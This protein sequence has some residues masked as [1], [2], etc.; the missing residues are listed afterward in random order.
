MAG[1]V[2]DLTR[3]AFK[4]DIGDI[5]VWGTWI[6]ESHDDRE[7]CLVLTARYRTGL[8]K[9]VPCCV[10]LSSAYKY[11]NPRYLLQRAMQFTKAL[12]MTDDMTNVHKVA[13]AIINHLDDLVQM[14]NRPTDQKY[15]AAD[16]VITDE[17]GREHSFEIVDHL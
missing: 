17:H 14:P 4:R 6:G 9:S 10:A 1:H 2:L 3:H 12:G 5:S 11:D 16:A 8:G 15:V 7:P 13:D